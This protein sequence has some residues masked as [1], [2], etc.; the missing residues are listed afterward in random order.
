MG[1]SGPTV[2]AV[3]DQQTN[4]EI[5]TALLNSSGYRVVMA[6]DGQEALD[7]LRQRSQ[8]VQAIFLD[9]IIPKMTGLG[10]LEK[11]KADPGLQS[12]PVIRQTS[13]DATHEVLEGRQAGASY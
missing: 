3:D 7:V 6:T 5:L 4:L 1:S 9:R 10:V 2:L 13:A 8:E 11:I 12:I